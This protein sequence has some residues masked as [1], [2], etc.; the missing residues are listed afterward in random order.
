MV[1]K[2]NQGALIAKILDK[3]GQLGAIE[4]INPDIDTQVSRMLDTLPPK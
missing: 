3:V 1:D 4:F 2:I